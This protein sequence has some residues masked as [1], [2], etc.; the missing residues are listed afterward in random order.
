MALQLF[1]TDPDTRLAMPTAY[2]RVNGISVDTVGQVIQ[3][4]MGIYATAVARTEG[5]TPASVM[6]VTLPPEM[7]ATL[8][9][10]PVDVRAAAYTYLKTLT[11][12]S[13]SE[14]V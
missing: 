8:L 13:G 1:F 12:F 5:G 10:S 6:T 2:A 9:G 3:L 7:Y 14:D 11:V 4:H